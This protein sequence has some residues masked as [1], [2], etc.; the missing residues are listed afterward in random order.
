MERS[1]AWYRRCF[2]TAGMALV[3]WVTFGTAAERALD[4]TEESYSSVATTY[5]SYQRTKRLSLESDFAS[6]LNLFLGYPSQVRVLASV[7]ALHQRR[8]EPVKAAA[9]FRQGIDISES[10][11]LP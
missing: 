4:V 8:G 9:F 7:G 5:S 1:L 3:A 10:C 2:L 11:G 6:G